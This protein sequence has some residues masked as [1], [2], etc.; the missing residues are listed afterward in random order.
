MLDVDELLQLV[1]HGGRYIQVWTTKQPKIINFV[2]LGT[3]FKLSKSVNGIKINEKSV[4]WVVTLELSLSSN[5]TSS[6]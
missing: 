5:I 1:C 3:H 4:F 6:M 2:S